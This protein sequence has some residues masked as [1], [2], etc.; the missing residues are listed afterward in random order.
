MSASADALQRAARLARAIASDI[1][2]YHPKEVAQGVAEDSFFELLAPQ[3]NEGLALYRAR[4]DA[5][6]DPDGQAYWQAV[7]DVMLSGMGHIASPM[8]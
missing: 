6:L 4:I 7:V 2:V 8:W 1:A 3:L 5:A